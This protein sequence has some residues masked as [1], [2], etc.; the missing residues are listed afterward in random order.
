[1]DSGRIGCEVVIVMAV[2][3]VPAT[4]DKQ[5]IVL[6]DVLVYAERKIVIGFGLFGK[7]RIENVPKQSRLLWL[8]IIIEDLPRYRT[9]SAGGNL[10]SLESRSAKYTDRASVSACP[11][12]G[13]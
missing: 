7:L 3:V 1:M 11:C 6:T 9:D 4:P 10:I 2:T 5:T 8:R 13:P 12:T